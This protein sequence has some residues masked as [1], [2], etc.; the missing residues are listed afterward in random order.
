M[1]EIELEQMSENSITIRLHLPVE[2]AVKMRD[3]L[4]KERRGIPKLN[5]E[6]FESFA[7]WVFE[8][9]DESLVRSLTDCFG[10]SDDQSQS[11]FGDAKTDQDDDSSEFNPW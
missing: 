3:E 4:K 5:K 7:Q 11:T 10:P 1:S 9:V 2:E 6:T 8:D